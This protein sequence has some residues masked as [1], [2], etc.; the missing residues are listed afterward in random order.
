MSD[1]IK[2]TPLQIAEHI[3]DEIELGKLKPGDKLPSERELVKELSVSRSSVREAIKYLSTMGYLDSIKRKG[4]FVSRKYIENKY[5][6][7]Q[8]NNFLKVA[9]IF[10][11]MEVRMFLENQFIVLAVKRANNADLEKMKNVLVKMKKVRDN[12]SFLKS[13]LEFHLTLAESTHNVVIVELMK[14]IIKRIYDN[15]EEFIASSSETRKSTLDT[16]TKIVF[17]IEEKNIEEAELLY[18]NHLYLVDDSLKNQFYK[19]DE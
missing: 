8:L 12:D 13:D 16:F 2:S 18:R 14:V 9:P 1:G 19:Q 15:V 5:A 7:A 10:D 6:N 17:Y 3:K 4:T 11:L